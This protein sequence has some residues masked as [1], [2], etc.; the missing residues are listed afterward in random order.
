MKTFLVLAG[1]STVLLASCDNSFS[2]RDGAI[3][4]PVVYAVLNPSDPF[5]LIRV[6]RTYDPPGVIPGEYTGSKEVIPSSVIIRGEKAY[7]FH[8]TLFTDSAGKSVKAWISWEFK[9]EFSK[10]YELSVKVPGYK[11]LYS[12]VV[13][14]GQP[15]LLVNDARTFF[16]PGYQGVLRLTLSSVPSGEQRPRGYLFRLFV[17]FEHPTERQTFDTLREEIP[18]EMRTDD[19]GNP[20]YLY[21]SPGVKEYQLYRLDNFIETIRSIRVRGDTTILHLVATCYALEKNFYNYYH[22]VRGFADPLSIR[23]DRPNY[24]N[25][26][27]GLGVFGALAVDSMKVRVPREFWEDIR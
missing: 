1:I 5:Q 8:D 22:I 13:V 26:E 18:L 6:Y 25:I 20:H 16:R 11:E 10:T 23:M 24:T 9:P 17:E 7:A 3:D 15:F 27:N 4:Q 14:P 19:F 12:R 21:A 2:P